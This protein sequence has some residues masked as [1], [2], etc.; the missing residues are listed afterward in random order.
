MK[1]IKDRME[2]LEKNQVHDSK[3]LKGLHSRLNQ[4]EAELHKG[5]NELSETVKK[6]VNKAVSWE[7][8]GVK[9]ERSVL[10]ESGLRKL[11]QH[12]EDTITTLVGK[13]SKQDQ[14]S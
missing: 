8:E 4:I 11:E 12:L 6:E 13:V 9:R 14:P 3:H 5:K 1:E 2:I 7:M 10:F